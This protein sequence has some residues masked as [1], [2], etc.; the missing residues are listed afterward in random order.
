M[1]SSNLYIVF[2]VIFYSLF[3]QV[4]SIHGCKLLGRKIQF[5]LHGTRAIWWRFLCRP[6]ISNDE[7]WHFK[8]VLRDLII[9]SGLLSEGE[10]WTAVKVGSFSLIETLNERIIDFKD[11]LLIE[12]CSSVRIDCTQTLSSEYR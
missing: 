9:E 6:Y 11:L 5:I 3:C 1:F 8:S 4:R 10:T 2:S 7:T 12:F